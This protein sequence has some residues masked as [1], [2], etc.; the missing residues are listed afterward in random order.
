MILVDAN[1][2]VYAHVSDFDEH[3][4]ARVWLDERLAGTA[5]VGLPW[6]SLTAFLRVVTNPRIFRR[7]ASATAAMG[8]VID[9]LSRPAAWAPSPT[10]RH[11]EIMDELCA[12]TGVRGD[13][14]PDAHLA[15]IAIG[16]GLTVVSNDGDFARFPVRWDNPLAR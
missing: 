2:L 8:Q 3:A 14:V 12:I 6:E 13:L 4:A 9:W 15:A 16:H 7:P 1:V 5:R 10:E 11:A